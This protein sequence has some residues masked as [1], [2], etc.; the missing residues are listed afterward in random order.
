MVREYA[1]KFLPMHYCHNAAGA[2][3]FW[4]PLLWCISNQIEIMTR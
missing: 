3:K 4:E 2:G 1:H